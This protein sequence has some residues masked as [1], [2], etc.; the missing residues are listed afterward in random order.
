MTPDEFEQWQLNE[1]IRWASEQEVWV[2]PARSRPKN[3]LGRW[4]LLT[5]SDRKFL[6]ACGIAAN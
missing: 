3:E 6:A 5:V 2:L 4:E 1:L